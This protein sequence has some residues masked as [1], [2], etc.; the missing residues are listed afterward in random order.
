LQCPTTIVPFFGDQFFW[1]EIIYQK[2]LGPAPIP[3]SQLNVENL[4][5]AIR[6]MLQSEVKLNSFFFI[7][8]KSKDFK[9]KKSTPHFF[10]SSSIFNKQNI[11]LV[12][13]KQNHGVM[14]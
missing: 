10:V 9:N 4:S 8:P 6:F 11:I 7:L 1:G 3:I 5:N 2:E 13:F 12:L 14:V